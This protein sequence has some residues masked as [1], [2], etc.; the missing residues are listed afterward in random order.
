[1]MKDMF[2]LFNFLTIHP[3]HPLQQ[4]HLQVIG[5]DAV[6]EC[7]EKLFGDLENISLGVS[8]AAA[9]ELQ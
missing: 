2:S 5:D 9:G 1:M 8:D 6:D 4:V 3:K 7:L